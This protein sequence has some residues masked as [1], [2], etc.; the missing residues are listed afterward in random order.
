MSGYTDELIA[1]RG[2]ASS[3]ENLITKPFN[4]EELLQTVRSLLDTRVAI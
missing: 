3:G 2:V 4:P 1:Q